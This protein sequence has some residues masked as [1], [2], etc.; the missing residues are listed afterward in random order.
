MRAKHYSQR[1]EKA[2]LGW[3]RRFILFHGKRHPAHMGREEIETYL[4]HLATK[5]KVAASTQ[6]QAL[7]AIL[8]LYRTVLEKPND[9]RIDAVR[10]RRPKRVPT[11]LSRE[12]VRSI[13]GSMVGVHSLMARLLYGGGLRSSECARLRVKDIDFALHQI[14]IR[15]GKGAKDR[16]TILPESIMLQLQAHLDRVRL[17]HRHDLSQG[18]GAT[19]LPYSLARKY[20]GADREW[21]WQ[22]VFPSRRLTLDTTNS[23][24]RR[25]HMST[26]SLQKAVRSAVK[27]CRVDKRVSTHTFRHSFATHLLEDGYDIRTVQ[28]LL[29]HKDVKTTMIYTHVLKRGGL[30]VR[31]P[32]DPREGR[33]RTLKEKEDMNYAVG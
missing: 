8:F 23:A 24:A 33:R 12:E 9:F 6:N 17:L 7:S 19:Y 13:L 26:S 14:V 25:H 28:D 30:A 21:I 29:G 32:L 1:T 3:I 2:Y 22:Y 27:L 5:R 11:V 15:D 4:S 20:P 31:S 10:A 18:F 16:L